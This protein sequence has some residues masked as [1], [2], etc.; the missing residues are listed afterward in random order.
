[1]TEKTS[2]SEGGRYNCSLDLEGVAFAGYY[3]VE[4]GIYEEAQEEA[5]D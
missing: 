5:G 3:F 2:A 4:D 1:V